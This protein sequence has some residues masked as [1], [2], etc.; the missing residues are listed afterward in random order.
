MGP[1][2]SRLRRFFSRAPQVTTPPQPSP[3][4]KQLHKLVR[5]ARYPTGSD[6]PT[7]YAAYARAARRYEF[8]TGKYASFA[9]RDNKIVKVKGWDN[10]ETDHEVPAE[11]IQNGMWHKHL[12]MA[13]LETD[14][15]WFR[16]CIRLL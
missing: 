16:V 14:A 10:K 7:F 3:E 4:S 6:R 2:P 12:F 11:S 13:C 8:E 15:C 1:A 5:P 9:K